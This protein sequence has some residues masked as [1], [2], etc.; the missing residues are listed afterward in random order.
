[1]ENELRHLVLE[2]LGY[3]SG[4]IDSLVIVVG[5]GNLDPTKDDLLA[6]QSIVDDIRKKINELGNK[7]T[8]SV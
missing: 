2:K 4:W 3:L 7:K 5:T 8:G 1:M 6:I